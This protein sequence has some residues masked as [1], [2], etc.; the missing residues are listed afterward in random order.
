MSSNNY[1]RLTV[2]N[3]QQGAGTVTPAELDQHDVEANAVSSSRLSTSCA[4]RRISLILGCLFFAAMIVIVGLGVALH[5]A[6]SGAQEVVTHN[7]T[8]V[9]VSLDGFRADYLERYSAPNILRLARR[10][11][12]AQAMHPIF[13]SVTFANHYTLATGL[14]AESHGIVA[15][16]F[17]D[18]LFNAS[19]SYTNSAVREARWWGGEPIWVTAEKFGKK[20]GVFFWPGSEAD[21]QGIYPTYYKAY[22]EKVPNTDRVSQVLAWLDL[23]AGERT[24]FAALYMSDV[25]SAGHAY[26]PD[27]QQVADAITDVDNALGQLFQGLDKR[28]LTDVVDVVVVSDHGMTGLSNDRVVYLSDYV[29]YSII[30]VYENG[31]IAL[32]EPKNPDDILTV[33]NFLHG[34]HPNMTVWL[35][36]DIPLKYHYSQ[37]RR[38]TSIFALA[39]EGWWLSRGRPPIE[40]ELWLKGTHGYDNMLH[41][42]QALFVAAG[43]GFKQN[44]TFP[45]MRNLDIYP[46]LCYRLGVSPAPN[47]GTLDVLRPYLNM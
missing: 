11:V 6:E 27:S 26:G 34:A 5:R 46:L 16:H 22:D 32:I 24:S 41:S 14:Y 40:P 21:I 7:R 44:V 1:S 33:Y 37:N 18:P 12:H 42:M 17:F 29:D 47:N 23:P 36:P 19:F 10:G 45:E 28:G 43:P 3:V 9:L 15:N 31:P 13:P 39:D 20:A 35:K 38:I 4:S 2:E 25:D 30:N 8:V